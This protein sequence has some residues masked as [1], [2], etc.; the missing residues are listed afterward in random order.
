MPVAS[1]TV[2]DRVRAIGLAEAVVAAALL[3]MELVVE[4]RCWD[5]TRD[6]ALWSPTGGGIQPVELVIKFSGLLVRAGDEFSLVNRWVG[7]VGDVGA[8]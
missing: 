7:V 3:I 6:P 2:A 4:R 8:G 1:P 5:A